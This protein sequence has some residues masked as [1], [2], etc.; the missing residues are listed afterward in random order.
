MA[1]VSDLRQELTERYNLLIASLLPYETGS[2]FF[3]CNLSPDNKYP[4]VGIKF[5]ISASIL[6]ASDTLE[7]LSSYLQEKNVLF[8]APDSLESIIHLNTGHGLNYCQIGKVFT[9]YPQNSDQEQLRLMAEELHN[10]TCY[11]LKAPSIP[12]DKHFQPDSRVYYRYGTFYKDKT[13]SM[14]QILE[15]R[16][17]NEPIPEHLA[18]PISATGQKNN[19]DNILSDYPVF[20]V[21]NQRGKG[22]VYRAV[23]LD[24]GNLRSCIVKEG[25]KH[26]E[27]DWEGND[28]YHYRKQEFHNIKVLKSLGIK[29]PG[30]VKFIDSQNACYIILEDVGTPITEFVKIRNLPLQNRVD[31]LLDVLGQLIIIRN[32]G[33]QWLDCKSG[34]ILVKDDLSVHLIDFE[35]VVSTHAPILFAYTSHQTGSKTTIKEIDKID[36]LMVCYEVLTDNR[37]TTKSYTGC[38]FDDISDQGFGELY[39]IWQDII[40]EKP[41]NY[42]LED[43]CSVL[44]ETKKLTAFEDSGRQ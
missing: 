42:S 35:S 31:M 9:I 33:K 21:L 32:E 16:Y 4:E 36:F 2:G 5:H 18:D 11:D 41:I 1:D 25:R 37:I 10:I 43:I 12:Y 7:R 44:Y 6:N 26:G 15:E 20:D 34:N 8:K 22:G 39:L 24:S 40:Q 28:G 3:R 29:V 17:A 38:I 27:I 13:K 14:N 30:L 19:E 23:C